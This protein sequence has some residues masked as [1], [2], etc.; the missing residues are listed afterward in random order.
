MPKESIDECMQG[1]KQRY[2][3]AFEQ[4]ISN[5]ISA[6]KK[7]HSENITVWHCCTYDGSGYYTISD[8]TNKRYVSSAYD[9][10]CDWE[11]TGGSWSFY[12]YECLYMGQMHLIKYLKAVRS[13]LY[14][15]KSVTMP[16]KCLYIDYILFDFEEYPLR[17]FYDKKTFRRCL[18]IANKYRENFAEKYSNQVKIY[19]HFVSEGYSYWDYY[20]GLD[21]KEFICV[22]N[23]IDKAVE[24]IL[25]NRICLEA[26]EL[27]YDARSAILSMK[28]IKRNMLK[29]SDNKK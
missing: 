11:C 23:I 12:S 2:E 14:K 24:E 7:F 1:F 13:V 22:A 21:N 15:N 20:N 5:L 29:P 19:N 17:E 6:I 27:W 16:L 28:D 3:N 8:G 25:K 9:L 26:C 18:A 4:D 10:M